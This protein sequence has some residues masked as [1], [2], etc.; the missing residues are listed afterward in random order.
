MVMLV[1]ETNDR[2]LRGNLPLWRVTT[3][4][5]EFAMQTF[6]NEHTKFEG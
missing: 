6:D 3:G 4:D 2:V 5:R 1:I